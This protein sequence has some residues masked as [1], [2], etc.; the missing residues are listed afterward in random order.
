MIKSILRYS[1]FFSYSLF[2]TPVRK[3]VFTDVKRYY[4]G[5]RVIGNTTINPWSAKTYSE[6]ER[7]Q[8]LKAAVNWL[9]QA[10]KSMADKGM[11]SYH[12]INGWTSSYV[13]T[14]GYI[15]SSLLEYGKENGDESVI[16][17]ALEA[18]DWLISVQKPSGGWQ[19]ACIDDQKDEVVFNTGQVIR[20]MRSAYL[21][22]DDDKYLKAAVRACDWLVEMQEAEGY[23]KK[24]AFMGVPR[25]Y[26]SYVDA[27]LLEIY[28]LTG[29]EA[30]K[31]AALKNLNWILEHKQLENGWFE[32]CDNTIKRN[33][34]PILHTIAYTIDG[35]LDSGI[36]LQD[37]KIISAATKSADRLFAI[38]SK[39]KFLSGRF[40]RQWQGSEYMLNTGCAQIV[41][42]WLKLYAHTQNVQY[43]NAALKM[44]DILLFVQ[45]R[46]P[47]ESANTKGAIPGSFPIWGRYEAFAF[48]NWAT[49]YFVDALLLEKQVMNLN[50]KA[51][52]GRNQHL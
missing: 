4:F 1:K 42:V 34:K 15:V 23:W 35:L 48:P 44:N 17:A 31:Q 8:G 9:L 38:F 22:T 49:K 3:L 51:N 25:V 29:N 24:F 40:D 5:Q 41:I 37:E 46:Q 14:T 39:N 11:G 30:Y 12:L 18:A 52:A 50:P 6:A 19:G 33:E 43:L 2:S 13:E 32:D 20:G 36:I 7:E 27:P 47:T 16:K 10:Q 45:D 28:Q 21:H 26:D